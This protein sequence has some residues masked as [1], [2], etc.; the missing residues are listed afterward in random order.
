M[1]RTFIAVRMPETY[2]Q[3]IGELIG[4]LKA[5]GAAVR[6][7]RPE[8][9]HITLKFLGNIR[10][11]L[12]EEIG[13]KISETVRNR[14]PIE[15]QARGCGAFPSLKNP[16]VVWLGIRGEVGLLG[17][18]QEDLEKRLMPLGFAPERR[19][20]K[21]HLTLG[22]LKGNRGKSKLISVLREKA[23]FE[24]DTFRVGEVILYRSDLKPTGAVYSALKVLSFT[25]E[26]EIGT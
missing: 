13:A 23:N 24:L 1:I 11:E 4:E 21:A 7:V 2:L 15:L 17:E 22:R 20:F 18:L 10:E 5:T 3:P 19:P 8:S 9:M 25:P 26:K 14:R 16:R 6:W 12:V